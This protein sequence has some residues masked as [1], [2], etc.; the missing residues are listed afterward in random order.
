MR[1]PNPPN[2]PPPLFYPLPDLAAC[3]GC[4]AELV[5]VYAELGTA[6]G[7]KLQLNTYTIGKKKIPG[8]SA[9]EKARFEKTTRACKVEN[10]ANLNTVER[11]TYQLLIGAFAIASVGGLKHVIE[12][13]YKLLGTLEADAASYGIPILRGDDTNARV[14]RESIEAVCAAGYRHQ[15]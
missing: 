12:Q 8:V 14:I 4:S 11:K 9:S 3:W 13:P 7:D 15:L 10:E 2:L 5:K 1:P 6:A